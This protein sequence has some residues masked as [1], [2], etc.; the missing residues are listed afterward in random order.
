[1]ASLLDR[2]EQSSYNLLVQAY[3]NYQ[4]G[5]TTG[6]SRNSFT[7]LT[8]DI[9]DVN[10]EAPEFV[11]VNSQC[12]TI[13]EFHQKHDPIVNVRAIDKDDPNSPNGEIVFSIKHGD[14]N[15]FFRIKSVG[16][17]TAK[18]YPHGSLKGRYGNYSLEIEAKD[19]GFPPNSVS[20]IYPVC[21]QVNSS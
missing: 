4:Y 14:E 2:E 6:D 12:T 17:G 20:A 13:S 3:D 11:E 19:K 21:V 1:M 16:R 15:G 10:D 9:M 7:Q 5:F 8:V 18:I